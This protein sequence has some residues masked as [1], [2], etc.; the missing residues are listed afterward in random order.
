MPGWRKSLIADFVTLHYTITKTWKDNVF[1]LLVAAWFG[2]AALLLVNVFCV[3]QF[4]LGYAETHL[5]AWGWINPRNVFG[6]L[7]GF[8]AIAGVSSMVRV[9]AFLLELA[10][11]PVLSMIGLPWGTKGIAVSFLVGKVAL[12]L[13]YV[14]FAG[15]AAVT[16]LGWA[17]AYPELSD[18]LHLG[19][20]LAVLATGFGVL[21]MCTGNTND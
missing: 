17:G 12:L 14:V 15:Y 11:V 7:L 9:A 16:F 20:W 8:M 2:M 1:F 4:F 3:V 5:D 13:G 21:A 18:W 10:L 19:N 6:Y